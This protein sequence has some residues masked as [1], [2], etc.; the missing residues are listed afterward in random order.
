MFSVAIQVFR[1]ETALSKRYETCKECEVDLFRMGCIYF[2]LIPATWN[3]LCV[4]LLK[5]VMNMVGKF[6][7]RFSEYKWYYMFFRILI[8]V[9]QEGCKEGSL[10]D[11]VE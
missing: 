8:V 9:L 10:A 7:I 1:K 4:L 5:W 2:L 11:G 3:H 6:T